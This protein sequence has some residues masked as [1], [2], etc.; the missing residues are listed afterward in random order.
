MAF[1]DGAVTVAGPAGY[2]IDRASIKSDAGGRFALL[3][4]CESLTG[5]PSFAV[6]P[7]VMTVAVLPR[8]DATAAPDATAMTD[9]VGRDTVRRAE[10]GDG[11][12][13]VQVAHGGETVLPGGDPRHWRAGM[14]INGHVVG[15]AAYGPRDGEIAGPRGGA[16][17]RDLADSLRTSSAP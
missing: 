6:E 17:L 7:A 13:L 2:C 15:L 11:I 4:S 12:T 3:A 14:M 10:E 8:A 1:Y 5:Q 16:L 9:A